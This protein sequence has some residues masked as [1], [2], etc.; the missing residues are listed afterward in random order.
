MRH[1]SKLSA[2]AKATADVVLMACQPKP[3]RRLVF[4]TLSACTIVGTEDD[5]TA[6]MRKELIHRAVTDHAK[7]IRG[8]YD[9][10]LKK[11]PKTPSGKVSLDWEVDPDG[12][13]QKIN[14]TDAESTLKIST[15]NKCLI[16]TFTEINFPPPSKGMD[17]HIKYPLVFTNEG[18]K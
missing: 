1:L 14:V 12:H 5:Q 13:A 6:K 8:C 9:Y 10:E 17:L 18:K 2:F 16:D 7:E 15:L 11:D 3:W 4:L